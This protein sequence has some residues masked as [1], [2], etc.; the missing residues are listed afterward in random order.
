MGQCISKKYAASIQFIKRV[1]KR[2][3]GPLLYIRATGETVREILPLQQWLENGIMYSK[4]LEF[5]DKTK[6]VRKK[7]KSENI[8]SQHNNNTSASSKKIPGFIDFFNIKMSDFILENPRDYSTFNDFFIREVKP[9]KRPIDA[10]TDDA[11]I[12][13]AAD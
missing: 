6:F 5:I 8:S 12:V 4:P 7:L 9:E 10:P 11:V 3:L 2:Q 1:Q 13:C